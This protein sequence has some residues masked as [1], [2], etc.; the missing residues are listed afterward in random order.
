MWETGAGTGW[1]KKKQ[2]R[3]KSLLKVP[4]CRIPYRKLSYEISHKELNKCILGKSILG[5]N[6]KK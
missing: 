5:H 4:K 1:R 6:L 2:V 3:M